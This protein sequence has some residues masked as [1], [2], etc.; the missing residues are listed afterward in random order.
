MYSLSKEN[1]TK[2]PSQPSL[3]IIEN[4]KEIVQHRPTTAIR[5]ALR[6]KSG[7]SQA[8]SLKSAILTH[9]D[10]LKRPKS[11]KKTRFQDEIVCK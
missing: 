8:K 1:T 10:E 7:S 5:S 4:E 11:F 9:S 3:A 2:S 6:K